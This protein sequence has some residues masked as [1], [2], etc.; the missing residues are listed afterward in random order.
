MIG[1]TT[2]SGPV[3]FAGNTSTL[4]TNPNSWSKLGHVLYI[5]QPVGTGF[6]TASDPYPVHDIDRVTSDF[7]KW[8]QSFFA[9]FPHFQSKQVHL[10]GESY[11]GF[12]IPYFASA[13]MEN[14]DSF[15]LHLE[16]L[17]IGDGTIGDPA[18]MSSLTIGTFLQ[19]KG[20]KLHI[21]KDVLSAFA[22]ADETCGFDTIVQ[23]ANTTFP[24][25]LT[26]PLQIP[27]NPDDLESEEG[28]GGGMGDTDGSCTT[29]PHTADAVLSAIVNSTC[30]GSCAT[31]ATAVDYLQTASAAGTGQ[32]CFDLYDV[33][34][35]CNAISPFTPVMEYF[36]RADVQTALNVP[37]P[38]GSE[39]EL[40]PFKPCNELVLQTL[41]SSGPLPYPPTHSILPSM[42]TTHNLSLHVYSGENDLL[43][44]HFGT[45]LVL[46][47]MT[48]SG[49]RG[50]A[51]KPSRVFYV[52]DAS[53]SA[54]SH[55]ESILTAGVW[56][57]ERGVSY[58]LFHG[59]GHS[60]FAKK[61]RE[62]FAFVRDVVVGGGGK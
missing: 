46:Q 11:A 32:A 33:T 15:P 39:S 40:T 42:V 8:L 58:H 60:V 29:H 28:G 30:G 21:P 35:D 4:E 45:E 52:D 12:Y 57:S 9:Q 2:G 53:P 13:I 31:F 51:Q 48:W 50:F 19:S 26:G 36:S 41:S 7:H 61:P 16:S 17:S 1:V 5:D 22:E 38:A 27:G 24:L 43:L 6:S 10:L 37:P 47:N 23:H 14:Q 62:M 59:A 20:P 49:A 18:A 55:D 25:P 44:N 3:S 54:D 34:N 56:G